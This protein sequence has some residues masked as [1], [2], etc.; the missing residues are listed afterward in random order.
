MTIEVR[1]AE[2]PLLIAGLGSAGRR[3]FRN[4]KSLGCQEL[5][6]LRT[7]RGSLPDDELQ[8]AV[9]VDNLEEALQ[10]KPIAAIVSNPTSMH[11]SAALPAAEAGCHLFVEKPVSDRLEDARELK[12]VIHRQGLTTLVGFQFRFHQS[13]RQIKSWL[14]AGAIGSIVSARASWGEY[15]PDWHPWEDYRGSYSARSDQG[16]GVLLTLCHPFDYLRWLLGEVEAVSALT[17]RLSDL[18]LDVE[19]TAVVSLRFASGAIGSVYLDF[20]QRPPSHHLHIVGTRGV[21]DWENSNGLARCYRVERGEWEHFSP[22]IGFER[23]TMFL[24]EMKHF[25]ACV[26]GDEPVG[27]TLDDGIRVLQIALA[28]RESAITGRTVYV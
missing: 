28:A 21:I 18:E 19:D 4:L 15:L 25:L 6:L 11:M 16:G 7:G 14:D 12:E 26:R 23:N 10:Y 27:C 1:A 20:V 5:I 17:G 2:G 9:A 24:D 8:G 22:P 13:L 3:H